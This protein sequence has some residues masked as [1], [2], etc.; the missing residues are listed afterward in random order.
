[1]RAGVIGVVDGDFE[2]VDSFSETVEEDGHESTRCLDIRSIFSLP[3]G[4]TAFAGRAAREVERAREV[5]EID[6]D[7]IQVSERTGTTTEHTSFVGVPG[8]IVAV[9]SGAGTFAFDLIEQET[10]TGIERATIDLDGFYDATDGGRP[11]R[12][13]VGGAAD[14]GVSGVVHGYDLREEYDL[15]GMRQRSS[16]NQLGLEYRYDGLDLKMTAT[17]S[18]YVEVYQPSEFDETAYLEYLVEQVVPHVE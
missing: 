13:G 18:G 5:A 4:A 12:A 10:N 11:W 7:G 1:M 2:Y 3:S 15:E 8:E 9:K 16:L 17:R 14:G 6:R